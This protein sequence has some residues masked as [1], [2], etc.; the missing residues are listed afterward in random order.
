M[1]K[2]TLPAFFL[3]FTLSLVILSLSMGLI[4]AMFMKAS[5]IDQRNQALQNILIQMLRVSEEA[6]DPDADYSTSITL[7]FD[8]FGQVNKDEIRY[9]IILNP[10]QNAH[11]RT[12]EIRLE[13]IQG[14]LIETWAIQTVLELSS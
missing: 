14:Y 9:K 12:V 6:R 10:T 4:L 8:Q 11:L 1:K 5:Q 7:T 3:E 13:D 2:Y